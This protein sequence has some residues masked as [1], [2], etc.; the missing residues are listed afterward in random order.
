MEMLEMLEIAQTSY[1][2]CV[3]VIFRFSSTTSLFICHFSPLFIF[4]FRSAYCQYVLR[5]LFQIVL[6]NVCFSSHF[7]CATLQ[8]LCGQGLLFLKISLSFNG[9]R[10]LFTFFRVWLALRKPTRLITRNTCRLQSSSHP[11][12][13]S[14]KV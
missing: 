4:L 10:P 14:L 7:F 5:R 3:R 11:C 8:F 1:F 6:N 2:I 9:L 12:L 13:L